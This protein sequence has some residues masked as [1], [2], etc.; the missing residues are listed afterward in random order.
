MNLL[1][2][3][4]GTRRRS[5]DALHVA[6]APRRLQRPPRAGRSLI[7]RTRLRS[8]LGGRGGGG[9]GRGGGSGGVGVAL[10][11]RFHD[12]EGVD[13]ILAEEGEAFATPLV[14]AGDHLEKGIR[15]F[16]THQYACAFA[17]LP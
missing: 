10:G 7:G 5:I 8:P 11:R 14:E 15:T 13:E 4:R 1:P 12:E 2:V 9:G 6:Q 16:T 17:P 3:V